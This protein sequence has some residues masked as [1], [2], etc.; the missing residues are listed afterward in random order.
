MCELCDMLL[1]RGY[2]KKLIDRNIEKALLVPRD[3]AIKRVVRKKE[4]VRV[5]FSIMYHPALPSIPRI[6]AKAYRPMAESDPRLKE[7]FKEPPMVSYRRPPSLREKLIRAKVPKFPRPQ[8]QM[9]GPSENA[10]V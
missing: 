5:V 9:R 8:T 10:K 4:M 3:E 6:I 2:K 7:V 1:S